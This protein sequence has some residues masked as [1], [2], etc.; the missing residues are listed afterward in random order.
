MIGG[1][2]KP[3]GELVRFEQT[4]PHIRRQLENIVESFAIIDTEAVEDIRDELTKSDVKEY[5]DIIERQTKPIFQEAIKKVVEKISKSGNPKV[6]AITQSGLGAHGED[7]ILQTAYYAARRVIAQQN[8]YSAKMIHEEDM[9]KSTEELRK[10][11][12]DALKRWAEGKE[13]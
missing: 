2:D 11:L 8:F 4:T 7:S 10:K 1:P 12:A 5:V 6:E 13:E 9:Y 3:K